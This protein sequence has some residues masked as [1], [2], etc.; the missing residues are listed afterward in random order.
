MS[1]PNNPNNPFSP[2]LTEENNNNSN[3]NNNDNENQNNN[4]KN[5]DISKILE[6]GTATAI[7]PPAYNEIERP[8][9]TQA[10]FDYP[11]Y[12]PP[13]FQASEMPVG[14]N[15]YST[16]VHSERR[17]RRAACC[18]AGN[19]KRNKTCNCG[20]MI[21]L[22]IFIILGVLSIINNNACNNISLGANPERFSFDTSTSTIF[23]VNTDEAR[24]R[25]GEIRIFQQNVNGDGKTVDIEVYTGATGITPKIESSSIGGGIFE[26]KISQIGFSIFNIPPRCMKSQINVYLPQQIGGTLAPN[27]IQVKNQDITMVG[28]DIPYQQDINL[29]TSDGDVKLNG[30][31]AQTL[32]IRTDDGDIVGS[33]TSISNELNILTDD[34]DLSLILGNA[35][36][37]FTSKFT[38]TTD[39][40]DVELKFD[41][42]SFS[43]NYSIRTNDGSIQI[44]NTRFGNQVVGATSIN[45]GG[46]LKIITDNGDVDIK[47]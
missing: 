20:W 32:N 27:T 4:E 17:G 40:G 25:R 31:R 24:V 35:Q 44:D 47:L 1:N 22:I 13:P 39:D 14:E 18:C 29:I 21:V 43:G 6:E 42:N 5:N 30:I 28:N 37:P 2:Y 8:Q 12:P 23:R 11:S 26:L 36:T 33:I 19:S 34:G 41:G 38:I 10:G 3:N 7:P 46:D 45:N 16:I 15:N 9:P